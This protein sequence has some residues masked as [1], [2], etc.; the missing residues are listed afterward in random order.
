MSTARGDR[1]AKLDESRSLLYKIPLNELFELP[2]RPH[3]VFQMRS[4][5]NPT[6][7]EDAVAAARNDVPFLFKAFET[8]QI[9]PK[10]MA[11]MH[12]GKAR[13]ATIH[14]YLDWT[15]TAQ[16][17]NEDDELVR[18][19]CVCACMHDV[20][21]ACMIACIHAPMHACMFLHHVH[22]TW[23]L[24]HARQAHGQGYA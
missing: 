12:G 11:K 6:A 10:R 16:G 5:Y 24:V 13:V 15:V 22:G 2:G 20:V 21:Y 17:A 19:A 23:Q 8:G 3:V 9:G 1:R 4:Y 7:P 14:E 18:P